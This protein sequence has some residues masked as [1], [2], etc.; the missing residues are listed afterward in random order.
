[1]PRGNKIAI[2]M[3][4]VGKRQTDKDTPLAV[5]DLD[6]RINVTSRNWVNTEKTIE[7]IFDCV[8]EEIVGKEVTRIIRR[9]PIEGEFS[10]QIAAILAGY[11]YGV[12]AAP[13][14]TTVNEIHVITV[15]AT[16]GAWGYALAY[17]GIN[18]SVKIPYGAPASKVK[19]MLEQLDNIGF[20]NTTVNKVGDVYTITYV[21]KRGAANIPA[22]TLD[23]NDLTGG[24]G[25]VVLTSSTNG[26]QIT[27]AITELPSSQYQP[28]YTTLGVAFE[29][30]AGSERLMVGAVLGDLRIIG[31]ADNGKVTF[32]G[33]IISRDLVTA[34]GLVI[35]ACVVYRPMRTADCILTRNSVDLSSLLK[36]FEFSYDNGILTGNTA[37]TGRG[38]RPARLERASRRPRQLTYGILGGV[39]NDLYQEAEANPEADVKRAYSLRIGTAGDNITVNIPNGLTELNGAGGLT[40]DGE[41][42]DAIDRFITTP[43]K[44]GSTL[45]TNLTASVPIATQLLLT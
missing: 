11:T 35:P 16:G 8:G 9:L 34:T 30:E 24:A 12:A 29:D 15:D 3:S 26:S 37:Y 1:M 4:G 28:P 39:T 38:Y 17:D 5:G 27:H 19:Y 18:S 36:E 31:A 43:T 13:S 44:Q 23:D 6:T 22:P 41:S 10:P 7:E 33:N 40:F 45:P 2:L 25:T 32:A 20:G 21:N 42:E 14:G